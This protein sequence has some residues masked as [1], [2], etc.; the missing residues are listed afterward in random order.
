[1]PDTLIMRYVSILLD[2]RKGEITMYEFIANMPHPFY[3][4]LDHEGP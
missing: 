4:R 3:A 2:R 1:M